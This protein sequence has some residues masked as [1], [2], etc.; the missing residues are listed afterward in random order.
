[1]LHRTRTLLVPG[2][3]ILA[4]LVPTTV[5]AQGAARG[6]ALE[7][8]FR[9]AALG[10]VQLAPDG[11]RVLYVVRTADLQKNKTRSNIWAV[12]TAGGAATQL[13]RGAKSDTRPRWRPDGAAFAFL[14][15]RSEEG[16]D[17]KDSRAA[18]YLM[19]TDGGEAERL[20]GHATA[21]TAFEWSPDGA[22]IAFTARQE[23]GKDE[24]DAKEKGRDVKI[25]DRP[26]ARSELWV[27]DV[28][29]RMAERVAGGDT[30]EVGPFAWSPDS[31]RIAFAATPSPLVADQWKSDIFVVDAAAGAAARRLT[32]NPGTDT[33]PVWT[34]DG[35]SIVFQ[36]NQSPG[37]RVGAP[38]V[39][40]IAAAGGASEDISPKPEDV[41][42]DD[43]V[44]TPD[45]RAAFFQATTGTTQTLFYMPLA[46]RTP[47]RLTPAE[48]VYANASI[49][50][51]GRRIAFTYESPTRPAEV[52]AARLDAQPKAGGID[53]AKLGRAL[54]AH[55]AALAKLAVG[56][57]ELLRW[58][59]KDGLEIEGL[60]VYPAGWKPGDHPVPLVV[61]A[62][63]GPSGVYVQGFQAASYGNNAQLYA[64]DGYAMLLP[65]PRGSSGRGD[66]FRRMVVGDWGGLDY[67]DIQAGVDTLVARGVAAP[68]SLGF[69]GWSYGGYMTA[70]TITQTS[71]YK[72][73]VD[74][75]GITEPI[76]MW[77]TQ[78]IRHVFEGYFGGGPYEP[79]KWEVY[80]KSSPLA[81]VRNVKTP[82][83]LLQ[84]ANDP[85]VPPNQAEIF[86]N[87]LK[88][89]S[90]PT[91]LVFLPRSG[92]GPSEPGLQFEVAKRQKEW[93][94]RWIRGKGAARPVT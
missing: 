51:D 66:A 92:H 1:M 63:G 3:A 67:Q 84:G 35:G 55:N 31:R 44:F 41:E 69:M 20:Y 5:R 61:K 13:T 34:P 80:Q 90:V 49:S 85:R 50:R 7:D 68:D 88:A 72:A 11:S 79:G 65:N 73:A 26:G 40:R 27:L 52:Y 22:R 39:F 71:R 70:W 28:A 33:S 75:A 56:R 83:L 19:R 15:D 78:D 9:A 14:S 21:I 17:A 46:T 25:E 4:L 6:P 86:F 74:G 87:A 57:T 94:D 42:P 12:P 89:L 59:S 10:D 2:C 54:T 93:M 16:K 37:Y 76:A 18:L 91:E 62:H 30:L 38:R 64:A 8:L 36:G 47:V 23:E 45:G 60:V 24:K 53:V 77:G 82:T 43:Y 29:S 58:K 81:H 32:T 48:G